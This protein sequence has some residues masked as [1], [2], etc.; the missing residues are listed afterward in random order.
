MSDSSQYTTAAMASSQSRSTASSKRITTTSATA[1]TTTT[2]TKD[3]I[4]L[5]HNRNLVHV[6]ELILLHCDFDAATIS[7][8]LLVSKTWNLVFSNQQMWSSLSQRL[9]KKDLL[10]AAARESLLQKNYHNTKF[11][12]S[13]YPLLNE[14]QSFLSSLLLSKRIDKLWLQ[15]RRTETRIPRH[16]RKIVSRIHCVPRLQ[17]LAVGYADGSVVLYDSVSLRLLQY[18]ERFGCY[19]RGFDSSIQGYDGCGGVTHF[20]D[21]GDSQIITYAGCCIRFFKRVVIKK[22][23]DSEGFT[24]FDWACTRYSCLL[25]SDTDLFLLKFHAGRLYFI[26]FDGRFGVNDLTDFRN[27]NPD[28][29]LSDGAMTNLNFIELPFSFSFIGDAAFNSTSH[30]LL[31][32]NDPTNSRSGFTCIHALCPESH[33]EQFRLTLPDHCS[34]QS[35][36]LLL[37]DRHLLCADHSSIFIYDLNT[38]QY[39]G[40]VPF[41][42]GT[43][44]RLQLLLPGW[45]ATIFPNTVY[46]LRLDKLVKF[47]ANLEGED[48]DERWFQMLKMI[49]VKAESV[50][51]LLKEPFSSFLR[52]YEAEMCWDSTSVTMI[53]GI[54][55]KNYDAS[56]WGDLVVTFMYLCSQALD[57][58]GDAIF[59]VAPNVEQD[60]CAWRAS[61]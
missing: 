43:G 13:S 23:D 28:E 58:H 26:T 39:I 19:A 2:T 47:A 21:D 25:N 32:D 3:I 48:D 44:I 36:Q 27:F 50:R 15:Q 45:I 24:S 57:L 22:M 55:V 49:K 56:K 53:E 33:R 16:H 59:S 46:V 11:I 14:R 18:F 20:L 31:A 4:V 34:Q 42:F 41:R 40:H 51:G 17:V 5:L 37:I 60:V 61:S 6:V 35:K 52:Y 8:A 12:A 54:P 38:H 7:S 1:S 29:K 9:A 10:F 30:F